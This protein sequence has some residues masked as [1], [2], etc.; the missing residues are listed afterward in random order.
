MNS[1]SRYWILIKIDAAG[2]RKIEEILPA[3]AFFLASF[4]EFTGSKQS[5]GCPNPASTLALDE[6]S[7]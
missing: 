2:K 3:K 5:T 1:A 6:G 7:S 4:P